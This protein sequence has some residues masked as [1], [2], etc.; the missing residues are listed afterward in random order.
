MRSKQRN[1]KQT[2]KE[3][4]PKL[5]KWYAIFREKIIHTDAQDPPYDQKRGTNKP[6]ERLSID[7]S[8]LQFVVHGKRT[9]A[10]TTKKESTHNTWT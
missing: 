7:Q 6:V 9:N 3:K 5:M 8:S 2:R 1:K 10:L 4:I